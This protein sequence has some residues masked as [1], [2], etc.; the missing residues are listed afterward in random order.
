MRE[1]HDSVKDQPDSSSAILCSCYQIRL[2]EL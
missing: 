2:S 1:A